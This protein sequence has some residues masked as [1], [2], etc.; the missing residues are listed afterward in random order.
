MAPSNE[1]KI[2][3]PLTTTKVEVDST[4]ITES[5]TASDVSTA[6]TLTNT[7]E[8]ASLTSLVVEESKPAEASVTVDIPAALEEKITPEMESTASKTPASSD[9]GVAKPEE[10]KEV[11]TKVQ[12]TP[13]VP[14]ADDKFISEEKTATKIA[15]EEIVVKA[16][17]SAD[18]ESSRSTDLK[19]AVSVVALYK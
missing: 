12:D 13:A 14:V 10:T 19:P 6:T 2:Q 5:K 18:A 9:D 7:K 11:V 3:E 1:E 16:P 17:E 8:E 4:P 15:E